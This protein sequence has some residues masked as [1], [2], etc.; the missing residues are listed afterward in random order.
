MFFFFFLSDSSQQHFIK[1]VCWQSALDL[2]GATVLR[3]DRWR[4]R[5]SRRASRFSSLPSLGAVNSYGEWLLDM[6]VLN[7]FSTRLC[8]STRLLKRW[9]EWRQHVGNMKVVDFTH[10]GSFVFWH[11][12]ISCLLTVNDSVSVVL[13]NA[14]QKCCFC[15]CF[16]FF[17]SI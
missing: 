14:T 6:S 15:F 11:R 5:N 9:E 2:S 17:A 12:D 10:T 13:M 8:V 7:M 3:T 1:V 4:W 16:V